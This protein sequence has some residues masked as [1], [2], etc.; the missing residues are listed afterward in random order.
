MAYLVKISTLISRLCQFIGGISL[1]II[2]LTT[3]LDV[4][5]RYVFKLTGGILALLKGQC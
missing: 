4:V 5:A 2:V 3:M 1:I